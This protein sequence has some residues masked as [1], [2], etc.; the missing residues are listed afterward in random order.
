MR[1]WT[2]LVSLGLVVS[3]ASIPLAQPT[4]RAWIEE[5]DAI[6]EWLRTAEIQNLEEVGEGVTQPKKVTLKHGDTV[7][8]A[9]YKPLKRGRQRGYWESYEAEVAAYL[10]DKMIG[11]D[12]VPPTV[13]RRIDGELGSLQL[14]VEGCDTYER[15][16]S[17]VPQTPQFSWQISNMK[18]FDNLIYNEDRNAGNFLLDEAWNVIL[19]DHSRAFLDRNDLIKGEHKLPVAYDRQIVEKLQTLSQE[20]LEAEL[21]DLLMGG[22]VEKILERRDELLE[23]LEELVEKKGAGGVLFN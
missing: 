16:Q 23:H 14:W 18:M 12:M 15:L 20:Q 5:R 21:G 19:I 3:T 1:F 4:P 8:H 2:Y 17:K 7:F 22:Q 9:I 11:L 13:V 10:L 6:E